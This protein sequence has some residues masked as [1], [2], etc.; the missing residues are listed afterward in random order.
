[1]RKSILKIV[2]FCF[3]I[4]HVSFALLF[5]ILLLSSLDLF[6]MSTQY[7]YYLGM[8][9]SVC[10]CVC[11]VG[12]VSISCK[13]CGRKIVSTVFDGQRGSEGNGIM[14]SAHIFKDVLFGTRPLRCANCG[15]EFGD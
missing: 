14:A 9:A 11:I 4:A 3:Y 6:S 15:R 1:M 5:L 10:A 8:I 7:A 12:S 2:A 13:F